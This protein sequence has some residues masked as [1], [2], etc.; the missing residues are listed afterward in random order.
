MI[1]VAI[2]Y[3]I[4]HI[5]YIFSCNSFF[6]VFLDLN[7]SGAYQLKQTAAITFDIRDRIDSYEL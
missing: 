5:P 2:A 6:Y 4:R 3:T 7:S 1:H